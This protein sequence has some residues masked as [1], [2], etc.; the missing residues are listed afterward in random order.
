MVNQSPE[1]T[2]HNSTC[3]HRPIYDSRFRLAFSEGGIDTLIEIAKLATKPDISDEFKLRCLTVLAR[4]LHPT[5]AAVADDI[6]YRGELSRN[7]IMQALK[8]GTIGVTQ[9][10]ELAKLLAVLDEGA[11]DAE[12]EDRVLDDAERAVRLMDWLHHNQAVGGIC[13]V[14]TPPKGVPEDA[15]PFQGQSGGTKIFRGGRFWWTPA[16]E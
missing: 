5:A 14:P 6:E 15:V 8:D 11:L 13:E 7:G 1:H 4:Y 10:L 9:A 3:S 16:K 12:E 2:T